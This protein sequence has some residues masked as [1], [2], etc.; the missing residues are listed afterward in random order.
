MPPEEEKVTLLEKRFHEHPFLVFAGCITL[1]LVLGAVLWLLLHWY[2]DPANAQYP[3]TAKKDLFQA[4]GLIM[5][6]VAGVI[7]IFFTWRN[8]NQTREI[9]DKQLDA[10]REATRKHLDAARETTRKQLDAARKSTD[11]T[12]RLT[13]RGQITERFT[14]AIDQLGAGDDKGNK[15]VEIRVGGIFA[16]G[17]IARDSEQYCWT[18]AEVLATYVRENAP[19]S[20]GELSKEEDLELTSQ[21]DAH[22]YP[23][24]QYQHKQADIQ[25]ALDM[26][27]D[28][29]TLCTHK[30]EG[31][32]RHLH[33]GKADLRFGD[34]REANLKD[35]R[36]RDANLFGIRLDRANLRKAHLR[37]SILK[38]AHLRKTKFNEADL[39]EVNFQR[40]RLKKADFRDA[41]LK[42]ADFQGA[43]LKEADFRRAKLNKA[44]FRGAKLHEAD[45][46]G[47]DLR[48]A[49][50]TVVQLSTVKSL[51]GAIM[52]DGSKHD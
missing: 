47:A 26:V 30:V 40:A 31:K 21:L 42:K 38:G 18:V 34:L 46:S 28:L 1:Y 5:A 49:V 2:I 22:K 29:L 35:A 48:E 51:K 25:A 12:L 50:V 4:L 15:K 9:T 36:F 8:L 3:S 37:N 14:H 19:W 10:A 44:D 17:Q 6:G 11:K 20:G 32:H 52:P 7:G 16:L 13:E 27:K 33:L 23:K 24:Y 39:E 41:K 45:L 43:K